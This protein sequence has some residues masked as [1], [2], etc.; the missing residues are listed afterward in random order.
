MRC[1]KACLGRSFKRNSSP[2]TAWPGMS[3]HMLGQRRRHQAKKRAELSPRR[4]VLSKSY[5][6]MASPLSLGMYIQAPGF[7][8]LFAPGPKIL[9]KPEKARV[10]GRRIRAK[11]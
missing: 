4:M 11:L 1:L 8:V 2:L 9:R 10:S 3:R 7:R 6:F 5:T